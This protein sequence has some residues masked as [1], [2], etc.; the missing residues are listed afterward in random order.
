MAFFNRSNKE[1]SNVADKVLEAIKKLGNVTLGD[2]KLTKETG[3]D[4]RTILASIALLEEEQKIRVITA[5]KK[6][7]LITELQHK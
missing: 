1:Q 2:G 5:P 7:F 6:E 3:L 4:A